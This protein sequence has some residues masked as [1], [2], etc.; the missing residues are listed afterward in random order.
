M[1]KAINSKGIIYKEDIDSIQ[2]VLQVNFFSCPN[3]EK[4]FRII[5]LMVWLADDGYEDTFDPNY[6]NS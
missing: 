6:A 5:L 3:F 2:K 1:A 4:N